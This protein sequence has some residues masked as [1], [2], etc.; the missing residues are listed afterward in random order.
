MAMRVAT[1]YR[2]CLS[3]RLAHAVSRSTVPR[4]ENSLQG[5]AG[6]TCSKKK[7]FAT[8]PLLAGN[9]G[10]DVERLAVPVVPRTLDAEQRVAGA[11]KRL[12]RRSAEH[13]DACTAEDTAATSL[14]PHKRRPVKMH[15]AKRR[16]L[17]AWPIRL[18]QQQ[19]DTQ[20]RPLGGELRKQI[21]FRSAH[22]QREL[23][24]ALIVLPQRL[25]LQVVD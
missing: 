3:P 18:L 6:Q 10:L 23:L 14:Y 22:A 25:R 20:G 9:C 17:L 2:T 15:T 13:R 11:E 12:T 8:S 19:R 21:A 1:R 4:H 7:E 24:L 16:V 5:D